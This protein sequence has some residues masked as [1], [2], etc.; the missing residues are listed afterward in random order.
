MTSRFETCVCA[1]QEQEI[2][3]KDLISWHNKNVVV[4]TDNRWRLFK[5]Q[6][7][8]TFFIYVFFFS[9]NPLNMSFLK[10]VTENV[11]ENQYSTRV[12]R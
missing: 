10:E 6:V 4:N 3:T 5:N 12:S 11:H 2:G 1:I 7:K 9:I 8:N